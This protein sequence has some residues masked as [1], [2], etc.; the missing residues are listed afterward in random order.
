MSSVSTTTVGPN[1]PCLCRVCCLALA[2]SPAVNC[3][4]RIGVK[5]GPAVQAVMTGLVLTSQYLEELMSTR[6]GVQRKGE[7]LS[8]DR[9]TG[10][11]GREYYDIQAGSINLCLHPSLLS[12]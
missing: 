7:V 8:A 1:K 2:V 10:P 9:R 6:L 4:R 3:T 12:R 11:D 5:A